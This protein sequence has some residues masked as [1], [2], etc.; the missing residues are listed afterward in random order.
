MIYSIK[1]C[2][3]FPSLLKTAALLVVAGN[4]PTFDP[5]QPKHNLGPVDLDENVLRNMPILAAF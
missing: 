3:C 2:K 4:T 5:P 1:K